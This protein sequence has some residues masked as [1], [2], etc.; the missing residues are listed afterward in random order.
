MH[1]IAAILFWILSFAVTLHATDSGD[2]KL[3]KQPL[4]R[5]VIDAGHGGPA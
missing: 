5:I 1:K 4:K 3:Q 2:K